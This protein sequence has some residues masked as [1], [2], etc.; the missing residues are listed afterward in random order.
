[1]DLAQRAES[2]VADADFS[3]V[4]AHEGN[5]RWASVFNLTFRL[6]KTEAGPPFRGYE[7]TPCGVDKTDQVAHGRQN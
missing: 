4:R 2:L 3:S 6:I 7:F 1:M 5:L